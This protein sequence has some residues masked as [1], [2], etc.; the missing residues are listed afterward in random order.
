M[1]VEII[2][3]QHL[4]LRELFMQHQEA[5]IQAQFDKALNL[6]MQYDTCH[7]AHML[8]EERYLFPEF[9]KIDR[10]SRWNSSLIMARR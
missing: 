6:L 10:R 9:E 1:L 3:K 2:H 7:Q 5:L 8:L 4:D